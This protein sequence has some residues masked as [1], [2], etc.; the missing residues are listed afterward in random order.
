M[1][2]WGFFLKDINL[3]RIVKEYVESGS[4]F[5]FKFILCCKMING[6]EKIVKYVYLLEVSCIVVCINVIKLNFYENVEMIYF[7]NLIIW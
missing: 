7:I 1:Y 5:K 3:L 2:K 4:S 6:I